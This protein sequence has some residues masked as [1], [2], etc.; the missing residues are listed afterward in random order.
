MTS[1]TTLFSPSNLDALVE[2]LA[3]GSVAVEL[4]LALRPASNQDEARAFVKA[5]TAQRIE[6]ERARLD[7]EASSH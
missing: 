3:D 5:F 6:E 1:P 2:H 4:V 7:A